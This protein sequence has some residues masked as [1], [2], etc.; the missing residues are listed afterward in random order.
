MQRLPV[1]LSPV[2]E[3][4]RKLAGGAS[5]RYE[6]KN[7][8]CPGRGS[9][10]LPCRRSQH[11]APSKFLPPRLGRLFVVTYSGGLRH[12]RISIVPPAL[13]R[14]MYKLPGT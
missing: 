13:W 3:A 4:Q 8:I 6:K 1:M 11:L 10:K 2:P 7:P 9:G 14:Q 12:R 5:H